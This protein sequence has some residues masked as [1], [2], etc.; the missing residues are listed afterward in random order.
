MSSTATDRVAQLVAHLNKQGALLTDKVCI[1]TGA[2][3]LFGIG[4]ATAYTLAKRLPKVIYVTDL[5]LDNL[6]ELAKDITSKY[7]GVQCI[8]RAVDAAS[9]SAVQAIVDEAMQIFG[10]LD[11]FVANAGVAS[12]SRLQDEDEE[13][14]MR[15]MRINALSAFLAL[16]IAG[17]AMQVTGK[18][19]KDRS[20]GSI[21]ATA[22][23][24]GIRS[25]AGSPEYS[26][27][28]AAV[29]NLCQVGAC[30]FAGTDIRVNAICPG[31]IETGMTKMTFDYARNKGTAHKIGQL[32]PTKRYGV[33]IEIANVI[34]FLASDEA[35]YLNGQA[36]AVDGGLSSS[37]PIVPGRFF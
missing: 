10:R 36:I 27:S 26:A 35:S 6:D 18:G 21:I 16:K 20:A 29:I 9:T 1:V 7:P 19:G 33:A 8:A 4:R 12:G 22:S 28:K 15:M 24:A 37:L 30:Q 23:V 5:T 17:A 14:F 31:L 32:N 2:S 25:G 3:S 13:S 34:A 11:V